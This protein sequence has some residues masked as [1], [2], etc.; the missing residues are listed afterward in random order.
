MYNSCMALL[1]EIIKTEDIIKIYHGENLSSAFSKLS[2]SHDA[3]FVFSSDKKYLG[4]IN[5]YYCLIKSSYPGNAKVENCLFHA[6]RI[7]VN[8]PISKVAQLFIESKI[9]YL[10]VFNEKQEF[11]GIITAR[12]LISKFQDSPLFNIS[13]GDIIKT[14]KK[15]LVCIFEDD[16]V[17]RAISLFKDEKISKLVVIGK[18]G[19]LRGI[20]SYYDL[21]NYLATPK[22]STTRSFYYM[23]VRNFSKSFVLTLTSKDKLTDALKLILKKEIGSVVIIDL[24][25][26]PIGI[27]TTK[28]ILTL[29]TKKK[30]E[31]IIQVTSKNLSQQS[32]VILGG[33]F[34]KMML[35]IKRTPN[36]KQAKL[37]VKEEKSGRLFKV[38][39]SLIPKKGNPKV[40]K[41][42][43][44]NLLEVLRRIRK[45]KTRD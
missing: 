16:L 22:E 32:R 20:L 44:K 36:V 8:F 3:A 35:F 17:T 7:K 6:P 42:E 21:I 41:E 13:I 43:G 37:L 5:P 2:T 19:R 34:D 38:V 11:I 4:V 26:N 28:D 29:F 24:N 25:R 14:K 40:I 39:L 33:F 31:D 45:K 9:H 30:E 27:I 1:R 15:P 12:R 23:K 18:D 10:P